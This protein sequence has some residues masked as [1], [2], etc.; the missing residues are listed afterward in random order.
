VA[1]DQEEGRAAVILD[2]DAIERWCY[3]E[4][5]AHEQ[6]AI[7]G[8]AGA[9]LAL[10]ARVKELEAQFKL[11]DMDALAEMT[12]ANDAEARIAELEADLSHA[13]RISTERYR[14]SEARIYELE[15][16][17]GKLRKEKGGRR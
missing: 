17:I 6:S 4:Q 5:R 8:R 2:L 9:I 15:A 12:R 10:V 11:S 16:E 3:R 7:Y 13:R 1:G 14:E